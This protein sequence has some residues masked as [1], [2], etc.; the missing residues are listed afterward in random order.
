MDGRGHVQ[1]AGRIEGKAQLFTI[2]IAKADGG[3][4]CRMTVAEDSRYW[5]RVK[6]MGCKGWVNGMGLRQHGMIGNGIYAWQA[7]NRRGRQQRH[8]GMAWHV[9]IV[10]W[11]DMSALWH[12]MACHVMDRFQLAW[13]RQARGGVTAGFGWALQESESG[14]HSAT[15]WV[16]ST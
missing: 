14:R 11:H 16:G 13:Y 12:G 10:T 8:C 9:G 7:A 6:R 2:L 4:R 3:G 15:W 5:W 1:A